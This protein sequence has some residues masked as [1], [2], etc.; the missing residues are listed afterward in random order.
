MSGKSRSYRNRNADQKNTRLWRHPEND[1][2]FPLLAIC[3][4]ALL[5]DCSA[6]GQRRAPDSIRLRKLSLTEY[7]S[8][9]AAANLD[10]AAQRYN[11]S[12]AKAQIAAANVSPNPTI[13]FGYT[14]A[15]QDQPYVYSGGVSQTIEVGGKRGRRIAVAESSYL[16]A[17]ATLDDFFRTL[18]GTAASAFIDAVANRMIVDQKRSSYQALDR[19]STTNEKRF[20][21]GDI[22]QVDADQARVDALQALDDLRSSESDAAIAA[23]ALVQ[24]MGTPGAEVPTPVSTLKYRVRNFALQHLLAR[25]MQQRPDVIAARHALES[26]RASVRLAQASRYPD[27]T[28]GVQFAQTTASTNVINPSPTFNSANFS[29]SVPLPLFNSYRGEYEAAVQTA[30]QS[31]KSLKSVIL[32]AEV[33]VRTNLRRYELANARLEPYQGAALEL[34]DKV[35]DGKLLSY[36]KGAATLLDVLVAQKAENDVHLAYIGALAER[37]KAL[38]A[39][40]QA[41]AIWDLDDGKD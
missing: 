38:V 17:A 28:I 22:D 7:L 30:L 16:T 34:A 12:I 3:F 11:V 31:E 41:A 32:K 39:L 40:E 9:V 35:L 25:A 15:N 18:R 8:E 2:L 13:S 27:L 1:F 4:L 14:I 29:V 33:D 21:A 24:L 5:L 26:A 37:A 10:Y 6:E 36:Q 23:V 19:L 20:H